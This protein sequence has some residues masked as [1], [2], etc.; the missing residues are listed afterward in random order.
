MD[1]CMGRA[2]VYR[3]WNLDVRHQYMVERTKVNVKKNSYLCHEK[4]NH[5]VL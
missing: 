5:V 2:T 4:R 3:S 1:Q